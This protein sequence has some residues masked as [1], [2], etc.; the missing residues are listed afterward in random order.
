[1]LALVFHVGTDRF[2]LGCADVVEVIPR[3]ELRSIPHAPS[4]VP[5]LFTYRGA[6]VPVVD[7][8][9]L[10]RGHV[11]PERLSSRIIIVRPSGRAIGLLAERVLDTLELD[12]RAGL[13]AGIA[14]PEA[15]YLGEVYLQDGVSTQR[16]LVEGLV[17][18]P[19]RSLFDEGPPP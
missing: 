14:S 11:C 13:R 9:L 5:G 19:L 7:L 1:M 15:P 16:V 6:I 10:I 4:F 2:A 8:C 12:P 18:G 3:V 17:R